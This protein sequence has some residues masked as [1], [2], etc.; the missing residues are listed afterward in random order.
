MNNIFSNSSGTLSLEIRDGGLSAWM[1]I[2]KTGRL[3]DEAEILNLLD[4]VGIK[5]GIDDAIRWMQENDFQKDYQVPFPVAMCQTPS[6]EAR[7]NYFFETGIDLKETDGINLDS[8]KDLSYVD[9][10]F[11]LADYSY[12]LFDGNS[13]IYNIFGE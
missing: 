4:E 1:T 12:N 7:L 9:Q 3:I 2:Q 5:Y 8:L 10:G 11:V 13:S 6:R